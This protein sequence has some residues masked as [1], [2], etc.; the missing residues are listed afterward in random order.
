VAVPDGVQTRR[1][2][3]PGWDP[4]LAVVTTSRIV[5]DKQ[6][7]LLI[8]AAALLG[9]LVPGASLSIVGTVDPRHQAYAD[10]LAAQIRRDRIGNVHFL[11]SE[12]DVFAYLGGFAAFVLV[13]RHQGC[14]NASLEAMAAGLPVVANDD[15]GTAEQVIDGET[16]YLLAE[17]TPEA[18]AGRLAAL[19]LDPALANRLG[20]AGRVRVMEHFSISAMVSRYRA[21]LGLAALPLEGTS[22]C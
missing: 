16:G 7:E 17:P 10:G 5:P 21:A 6:L 15:G 2:L 20:T 13:S 18:I 3:P 1:I 8:E 14:P 12:P 4:A 11:G 22:T 9:R 19:L